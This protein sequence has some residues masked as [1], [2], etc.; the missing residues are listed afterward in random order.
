MPDT[1][2]YAHVLLFACPNCERPLVSA[3]AS[4]KKNLEVAEA[5]WF[6]PHCLCGWTGDLAGVTALKH[7]VEGWE[8]N[9][10]IGAGIPG[11]CDGEPLNSGI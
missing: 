8:G 7:W 6:A 11:S 9:P 2:N 5:E 3:C 4:T 1:E 10:P